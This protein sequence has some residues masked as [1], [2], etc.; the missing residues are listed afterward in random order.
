MPY[1][2]IG[3]SNGVLTDSNTYHQAITWTN[4]DFSLVSFC[5]HSP[6]SNFRVSVQATILYND[7]KKYTFAITTTRG[8]WVNNRN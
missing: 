8:R 6:W 5:V 7:F 3:S 2:N 1:D 4:D